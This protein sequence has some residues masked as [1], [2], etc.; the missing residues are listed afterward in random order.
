MMMINFINLLLL[1]L[2]MPKVYQTRGLKTEDKNKNVII[3][4]IIKQECDYY[5]NYIQNH[6]RILTVE[7]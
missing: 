3:I 5:C 2:S 4:V 6:E 7:F 1:L